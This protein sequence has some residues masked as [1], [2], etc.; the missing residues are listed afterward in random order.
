[1]LPPTLF[2]SL[3]A[4]SPEGAWQR[5][6]L[7]VF[8]AYAAAAA[9][10]AEWILSGI[11]F[12]RPLFQAGEVMTAG[13]LLLPGGWQSL[14]YDRELLLP[15]TRT[16]AES[17]IESHLP[18]GTRILTDQEHSSPR[19]RMSRRQV[20]Q[21][22]ELTR[23]QGHPRRK[24]YELMLQSHPG[25]GYEVYRIL[26][27]GADLRSGAWHAAWSAAGKATLDVREGLA[28]ARKAGVEVVV[29]T[30]G[31]VDAAKSPEF[32]PFLEQTRSTGKL[33]AEFPPQPGVRAGPVIEVYRIMP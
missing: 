23:A 27:S 8:P 6:Q 1:M 17:W 7:A 33:L 32:K 2:L 9:F 5:Y 12:S 3:L 31:G 24:F 21:L 26:R 25:G 18:E 13:L 30:S 10:G 16:L 11:P 20:A 22:L 29:L 28:A 14:R 19:I 4:L 15:D